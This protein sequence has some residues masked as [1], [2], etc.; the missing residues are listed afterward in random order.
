[1]EYAQ[2]KRGMAG[3]LQG[4]IAAAGPLPPTRSKI[5]AALSTLLEAGA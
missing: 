4:V 1:M 3:A 5:I 2:T